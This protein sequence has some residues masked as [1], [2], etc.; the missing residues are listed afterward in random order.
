V[1]GLRESRRPEYR[2]AVAEDTAPGAAPLRAG[3]AIR[4]ILTDRDRSRLFMIAAIVVVWGTWSGARSLLTLYGVEMLGLTRGQAGG[5]SLPAGIA[6]LLAAFPVAI[7]SDRFGRRRVMRWGLVVFAAS[8]LVAFFGA[9]E[10]ATLVGVLGMAV[11]FTGFS[12]NAVV[13]LWNLAT[14]QRLIGLYT[15]I[16]SVA[17]AIG[18]SV[19]PAFLGVLVDA[20][21]WSFLMLFVALLAAVGLL[22]TFGVRREYAP[23]Q[24]AEEAAVERERNS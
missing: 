14:T 4:D 6:Y 1:L 8:A 7:V 13:M 2:A 5:F 9:S 15:G 17:C 21:D 20:T 11:G 24:L 12:I 22:L 19:T 16:F 3:A 10:L 23:A 18:S